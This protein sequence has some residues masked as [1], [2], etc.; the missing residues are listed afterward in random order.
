MGSFM[1]R[2]IGVSIAVLA[3]CACS[4]DKSADPEATGAAQSG[5]P[6]AMKL[7]VF[8]CGQMEM[9][10]LGPF[11]RGGAYNGRPGS[12]LVTCYLIRHPDGDFLWDAGLPDAI[13]ENPEGVAEG[14]FKITVPKTLASQLAEIG[15]KPAD[16]EFFSISHSHFDHVGNGNLFAGSTFIVQKAERAHMFRDAARADARSFAAYDKL[17][18]AKM[19]EIEGD[20]DVFGDGKVMIVSTP[21]HTPGHSSLLIRLENYGPFLLTGDLYHFTEAREKRTIPV[22]NTDPEETLRSMDKFESLASETGAWVMIQHEASDY[23]KVKHSP[24]YLD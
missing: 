12:G 6:A 13:A 14:G 11:D 9:A 15:V 10:D 4:K 7:Y 16:I 20:H 18:T 17:E 3:L 23:A 8:D 22:F 2:F 24:E 21:G 5:T 1:H 19:R